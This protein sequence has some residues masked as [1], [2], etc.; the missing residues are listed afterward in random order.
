MYVLV[1]FGVTHMPGVRIEGLIP[2]S[3][4]VVHVM[5]FGVWTALCIAGEFFGRWWTARNIAGAFSVSLAY[6]AVDEA[7]QA[8]PA[9]NRVAAWDD[10][11]ANAAGVAVAALA[12]AGLG[13]ALRR[14]RAGRR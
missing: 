5:V 3:D 8:I 10:W 12:A 7:T 11:L 14:G 13:A 1:V 2:R 9:L 4:L 6:S